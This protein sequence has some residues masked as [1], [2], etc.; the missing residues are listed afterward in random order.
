MSQ[1][2]T[3]GSEFVYPDPELVPEP[4][5]YFYKP[6]VSHADN[7]PP[8]DPPQALHE[9]ATMPAA[10]P[11]N[12]QGPRASD[13]AGDFACGWP[14]CGQTLKSARAFDGHMNKH[15][16]EKPHQCRFG[17]GARFYARASVK[18]RHEAKCQSN[19]KVI[20]EEQREGQVGAQNQ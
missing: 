15:K 10:P 17:C 5:C 12:T 16:E 8:S 9:G 19:P 20:A 18:E 2:D 3:T 13:N 11:A 4:T 7:T 6:P 1:S 14:N